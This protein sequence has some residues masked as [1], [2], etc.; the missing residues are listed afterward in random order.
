MKK[1]VFS[2]L[3][4]LVLFIVSS[5]NVFG[6]DANKEKTSGKQGASTTITIWD[7]KYG[8]VNSVQPAMK[9][10]DDL[11]MQKNPGIKIDHVGQ[12]NNEYYQ[13][14]RAAV[15]AGEGPDVVMFHGGVQA[16][17]FDEFT[18]PLDTY[19]KPWRSEISEYSWAFCSEGGDG[20]KPVHLVPLTAQGF[21][22]YYNKA[23]FK[24]A[25]LDPTKAPSDY[26][27][28]MAA[29]EKLKK[30]GITPIVAGL[31]GN[32]YS[33]DFLLR[34]FVANIYGPEVKEL[35]T[36]KQNFQDNPAFKEAVGMI[37][38]MFNKGYIDA[39]GTSVP[40]FMDAISNYSAGKGAMFIG[41][42]SDVGHWKNFCDALGKDNIGYFPAINFPAAKY[43][44]IQVL[45]P[46]GIGYAIMNWSKHKNEAAKVI[47]GYARGEGN[48]L[49]MGM[50]GALSPNKNLDINK[51]GYPLVGQILKQTFASDFNT[52]LTNEDA[53]Q[54]M[55]RYLA[56]YYVSKEITEA[57]LI[58]SLQ[59]ML[60]NA[61]NR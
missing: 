3:I 50:T 16:Y 9:K 11:I 60:V 33:L 8:D 45:Q 58:E 44:N 47:E 31:Q 22:I 5:F 52:L 24:K 4:L 42:L 10:I 1:I 59:K 7:F 37:K 51:L 55:D 36:G 23:Y 56:Q 2:M 32:P 49:W 20:K 18:V 54:N 30:A 19:I 46:C 38:E 34:T 15:Q 17:E 14:V 35:V 28:F 53:N 13:L 26:T 48:A 25:G 21:G 43:K 39:S 57:Q 61:K 27:S 41:L 12:P 29:C 40:Y 6:E